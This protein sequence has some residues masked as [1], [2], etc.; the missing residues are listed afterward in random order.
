MKK[1]SDAALRD[2]MPA[3]VRDLLTAYEATTNRSIVI[4][5]FQA[6]QLSDIAARGYTG[7][8]VAMAV[9]YVRQR[10][11]A[12]RI[13]VA[14]GSERGFT[15]ASLGFQN[16]LGDAAKFQFAGTPGI[17]GPRNPGSGESPT[18]AMPTAGWI[19][20]VLVM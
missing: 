5:H 2:R 4:D 8:D 1:R 15:D 18:R 19:L 13:K 17:S 11:R 16:L 7:D 9:R 12:P 6:R 3:A 14:D 20:K 10:A